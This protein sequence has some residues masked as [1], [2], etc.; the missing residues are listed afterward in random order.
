VSP[1]VVTIRRTIDAGPT[2]VL[3][4]IASTLSPRVLPVLDSLVKWSRPHPGEQIVFFRLAPP[5]W[6]DRP[7]DCP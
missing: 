5:P 1:D 3:R 6:S 4:G 2:A 7:A